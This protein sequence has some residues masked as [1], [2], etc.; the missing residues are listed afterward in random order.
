KIADVRGP[1][2]NEI[3][4]YFS[5]PFHENKFNY[6]INPHMVFG[7]RIKDNLWA[8]PTHETSESAKTFQQAIPLIEQAFADKMKN[9]RKK[10]VAAQKIRDA[11]R[12]RA[13]EEWLKNDKGELATRM[14]E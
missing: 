4:V 5:K 10:I 9:I 7:K 6:N 2:F 1:I 11:E 12:T 13:Y 3:E 8:S 14:R